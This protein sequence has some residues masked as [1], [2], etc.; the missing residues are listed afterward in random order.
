MTDIEII[1]AALTHCGASKI[2]SLADASNEAVVASTHWQICRD[3]V[4]ES[5]AWLF[6]TTRLVLVEDASA[7]A[8]GYAH[9]FVIPSTVIRVIQCYDAN[10]DII[11]DWVREGGFI[12]TDETTVKVIVITRIIDT[13]VYPPSFTETLGYWLASALCVPLTENRQRATDLLAIAEKK[14]K[15]AAYTEGSQSRSQKKTVPALPGRRR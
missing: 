12:L 8:F 2:A 6:A 5:R 7:P 11:D 13:S 15:E 4:L 9:R 10:E 14:V 3:A 1:N